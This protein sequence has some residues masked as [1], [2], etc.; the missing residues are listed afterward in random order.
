IFVEPND[1][2]KA[3][4]LEFRSYA[5]AVSSELAAVG[6]TP[7]ATLLAAD[8]VGILSFGQT[9]QAV[10]SSPPVSV[11]FGVG[12]ASFGGGGGGVGISSGVNVPVGGGTNVMAV[13]QLGLQ[14]KRRSEQTV[15]WEGTAVSQVRGGTPEA[16][17]GSAVPGLARALLRDFP[18]A[19]GRTVNYPN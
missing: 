2:A 17:L 6:F 15:I 9:F 19:A 3:S 11:G 10:S 14:I 18:G 12:G 13:S 5:A 4:E 7:V 16:S 1:P 8:Y